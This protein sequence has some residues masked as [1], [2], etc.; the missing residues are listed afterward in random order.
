MQ[1][2]LL[3]I[4]D[5]SLHF[6]VFGGLL[7]VLDAINFTVGLKEKVGLI[8]EAGC[9]K[10]TT[11]K[12]I[13]RILDKTSAGISKGEIL[14]KG[15]YILKMNKAE[16]QELRRKEISMVFQDPTAALNPFFSIGSQIRSIIKYTRGMEKKLTEAEIKARAIEAL[17]EVMLPDPER[18]LENYPIQ[19]SGGM[20][21]RV[22]IAMALLSNLSLLIADEPGTSLDVTIKDQILHLLKDLVSKRRASVILISHALGMVKNLTDRTYVM[23]GG[24]MVEVAK[25]TELFTNPLHPYS[26]ALIA[27]V[28]KLTGG[29]ISQGI[30]GHIPEYLNPPPGCR[31]HPRCNYVIP[32]CKVK[33]PPFFKVKDVHQVAC[34]L[35]KEKGDQVVK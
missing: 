29:G 24:S 10:T 11:M 20:R 9:G 17:K 13:M 1:V 18:I 5:L 15:R 32:I 31:F 3:D 4:K 26:Q 28:P 19:L 23:Y 14:F 25:T 27:T 6:K 21:Q 8:G 12:A 7:K 16:L 33:K 35:F 22:C 2:P 34:W 30:P